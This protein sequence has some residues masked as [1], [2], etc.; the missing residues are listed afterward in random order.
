MFPAKPICLVLLDLEL[1][2]SG[3]ALGSLPPFAVFQP[4]GR[5]AVQISFHCYRLE[6][7]LRPTGPFDHSS[8][9]HAKLQAF[10]AIEGIGWDAVKTLIRCTCTK[11]CLSD[12]VADH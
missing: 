5:K 12:D 4:S 7:S 11:V 8:A 1:Q 9:A 10:A 2:I 3:A 6:Q